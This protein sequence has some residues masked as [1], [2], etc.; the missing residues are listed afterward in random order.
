[1]IVIRIQRPEDAPQVRAT[2][3]LAFG[4]RNEADVVDKLCEYRDE[5]DQAM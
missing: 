2:N 1:M 4:R 3:Q 5:V